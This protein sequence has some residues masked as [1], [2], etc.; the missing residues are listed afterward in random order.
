[1]QILISILISES[2]WALDRTAT[3]HSWLGLL[4]ELF[5]LASPFKLTTSSLRHC[6]ISH[7][8]IKGI[9]NYIYIV[10]SFV[11]CMRL[12]IIKFV[13]Q[14]YH[15]NLVAWKTRIRSTLSCTQRE[16][17]SIIDSY[18]HYSVILIHHP[19]GRTTPHCCIMHS[20]Y[21]CHIPEWC[22]Q[23]FRLWVWWGAGVMGLN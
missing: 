14:K 3:L 23:W 15:Y 4:S 10:I 8:S 21:E 19:N 2:K 9:I 1:M 6:H 17:L 13:P 22:H 18:W 16:V 7:V 5:P 20:P 11:K 12:F